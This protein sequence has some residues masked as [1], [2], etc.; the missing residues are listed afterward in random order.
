M[1]RKDEGFPC[2]GHMVGLPV[3]FHALLVLHGTRIFV[4]HDGQKQSYLILWSLYGI[5]MLSLPYQV[6]VVLLP[7]CS[8][9]TTVPGGDA[10]NV[11]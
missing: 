11:D 7:C 3:Q 2:Y 5:Y 6:Q 9:W 10:H 8:F 1:H 4:V